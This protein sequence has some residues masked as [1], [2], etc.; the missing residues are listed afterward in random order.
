MIS[1]YK[2][3][4]RYFEKQKG[5]ARKLKDVIKWYSDNKAIEK[6]LKKNPNKVIYETFTDEFTPINLTLTVVNPGVIGKEYYMT[7]GH[8]HR[9]KTPEFYILLDGNGKLLIQKDSNVKIIDLKKGEIALIPT[10]YAH[11]LINTGKKKLKVLTIYDQESKPDYKIKFKKR[12]FR[13]WKNYT[14]REIMQDL[15]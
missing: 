4:I 9:K 7:K 13:K 2:K 12:F 11:R 3:T 6:E 5:K 15:S 10:N 14:S 1:D 8:I